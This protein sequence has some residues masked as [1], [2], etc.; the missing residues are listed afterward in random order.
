VTARPAAERAPSAYPY[1]VLAVLCISTGSIFVRLAEAPP[2]TVAF[3]RTALAALM[4]MPLALP[5]LR[6]AWPALP[7]HSRRLVLLAGLV[8]AV[9]FAT[10]IQSL[11]H[12]SIASSVLLVNTAPVFAVVL[13]R[14]FLRERVTPAVLAAIAVALLG[15]A[16]I[17]VADWDRAPA[18]LVGS[19]LALAGAVTLAAYHVLGRGLREAMP[20]GAYV[21]TVWTTAACV[22]G[23]LGAASRVT[24]APFPAHTW[25]MLALLALVPTVFGHGLVNG[26]LRSIPAPTVGLFLLGEPIVASVLAFLAFGERPGA[27]GLAGGALVLGA[28]ALVVLRRDA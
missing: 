21:L 7:Q 13:S 23:L 4:L 14:L 18:S 3:Y 17:A 25:L 10:W 22:L 20:L 12:T 6:A 15:A 2:L 26:S 1:L 9:H 5:S 16:L 11:R 24:F 19:L 8:L 27:A 28:L